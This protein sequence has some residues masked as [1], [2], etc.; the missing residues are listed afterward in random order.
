MDATY[1]YLSAYLKGT[2]L[3]AHTDRADCEF[4]CSY[5]IGKPIDSNWNIYVH[6]TKQPV[7]HKGR[8]DFTPPKEEC[9]AVDCRENGLMI[10]N[11]M[12]HIHFREELPYDY[13]NIV[14]LHYCSK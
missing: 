8:Y 6:K 3:P 10:F 7:K 12:D 2:S 13:Y 11:G 14:L 1:T 4:T 5:I 9:M